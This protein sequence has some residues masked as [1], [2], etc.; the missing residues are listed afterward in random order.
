MGKKIA[1]IGFG[2]FI[3]FWIVAAIFGQ[4]GN[5]LIP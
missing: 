5:S 3:A 2:L 1:L 4:N